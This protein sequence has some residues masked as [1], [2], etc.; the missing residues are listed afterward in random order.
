MSNIH[1][2][3]KGETNIYYKVKG[4][5]Y[6]QK[7]RIQLNLPT[8]CALFLLPTISR[9][10]AIDISSPLASTLFVLVY[11]PKNVVGILFFSGEGEWGVEPNLVSA[12]LRS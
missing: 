4:L 7:N 2:S 1:T 8:L 9:Y 6:D 5:F 3:G 12:I 11:L 10:S